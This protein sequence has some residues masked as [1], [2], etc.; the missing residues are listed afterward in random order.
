MSNDPQTLRI[1]AR[2][3]QLARWQADHIAERLRE[4]GRRV[5]IVVIKTTGDLDQRT[6]FGQMDAKGIFT[7]EIEEALL[8]DHIDL[9]VHSLK[10]LPTRLPPGLKLAAV[11]ERECPLDGWYQPQG[12][13]LEELPQGARVATGSLRRAAQVRSLRGDLVITNIRGN[14][15]TR[16]RKIREGE[17]EATL[18]AVA[19][20]RRLGLEDQLTAQFPPDQVTPPMGQG[21]L[22]IEARAGDHVD[23]FKR[24]EHPPSRLAA[25]AERRFLER[26]GGG[27][28][29]P[30]GVLADL[31]LGAWRLWTMLASPDGNH[32][33]RRDLY[34]LEAEDLVGHA[35]EVAREMLE[36]A[37][38][39]ILATLN[40]SS[41]DGIEAT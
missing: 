27:C 31:V 38:P 29:T 10:D 3:S 24:L 21:A 6:A 35:E 40:P 32:V 23:L 7:K 18:L 16:L 20:L 13:T 33:M 39:E 30:A 36:E 1:G 28:R 19:G 15:T 5:E 34:P 17:A 25:E 4:L 22:A 8:A 12:L 14:V 37:P 2:G 41:S 9:A 26:I 11:T